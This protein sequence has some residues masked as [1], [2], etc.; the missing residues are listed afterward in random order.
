[1]RLKKIKSSV[2]ARIVVMEMVARKEIGVGKGFYCAG[3]PKI[4]VGRNIPRL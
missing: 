3:N 2:Q 1:M 4:I